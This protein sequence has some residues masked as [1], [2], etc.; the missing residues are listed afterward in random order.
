MRRGRDLAELR[1]ILLV[2]QGLGRLLMSIDAR[3]A[4]VVI[5]LGGDD[6]EAD[7]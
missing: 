7:A 2:L 6:E 5:L 1:E 3:L 4:D